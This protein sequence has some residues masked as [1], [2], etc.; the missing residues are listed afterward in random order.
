VGRSFFPL[1]EEL[2]LL[3]GNLSP[4]GYEQLVRLGTWI[5]S[6]GRA[7]KLLQA[8]TGIAVSEASAR[9]QTEK[10]GA[11]YVVVQDQEEERLRQGPVVE[12]QG[13]ERLVLGV[14]GALVP[15]VGHEWAEVKTLVVGEV[16]PAAQGGAEAVV[17]TEKLS[18]F[19]RLSEAEAFKWQATVETHRRGVATAREVATVSD[20]AEWIQGF[21]RFHRPDAVRILDLPHVAE[22]LSLMGEAVYGTDTPA[23]R[24][25]LQ[26][27]MTQL[28]RQ[29]PAPLLA[30]LRSFTCAHEELTRLPQ[31]LAYLEKRAEQMDYPAYQAAGWPIG[32]GMVESANKLLVEGRLK[33]SGMHW[34][35]PHVNPLL[36][37]RNIV[38]N[39]RWDE[40]WPQIVETLRHGAWQQR[41]KRQQARRTDPVQHPAGL[42]PATPAPPMAP[43]GQP[44]TSAPSHPPPAALRRPSADHPWH[45]API[46]KA[47]FKPWKP[48]EPKP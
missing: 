44:T 3:P 32:S 42:A 35:R 29:G 11:A 26:E 7:A 2:G 38:Y 43:R 22:H 15:L 31:H 33:G 5:A 18:Y 16:Q 27:Q 48:Y 1:D 40:A 46:G 6:F 24:A 8:L 12:P 28:K 36:A 37:L 19:S 25:W 21:I 41:F 13:G 4:Y 10:A 14:D 23:A 30:T 20:G 39:D 45:H 47:R 17:K 34:A 9:R